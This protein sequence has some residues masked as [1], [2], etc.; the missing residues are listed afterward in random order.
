MAESTCATTKILARALS[1]ANLCLTY[2]CQSYYCVTGPQWNSVHWESWHT[3]NCWLPTLFQVTRIAK[4]FWPFVFWCVHRPRSGGLT[5]NHSHFPSLGPPLN[6]L[7]LL[8]PN[9]SNPVKCVLWSLNI[10]KGFVIE[11]VCLAA[12][13]IL[14]RQL[15]VQGSATI[16]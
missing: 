13:E 2:C 11:V 10:W 8:G 3:K 4:R 14:A 6:L 12:L 15:A 7:W 9:I 5:A 16:L 1:S